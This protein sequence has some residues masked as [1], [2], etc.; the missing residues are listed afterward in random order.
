MQ[1]MLIL[2]FLY[3]G[4]AYSDGLSTVQVPQVSM[5]ECQKNLE[6]FSVRRLTGEDKT[7]ASIRIYGTCVQQGENR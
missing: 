5:E 3:T 4:T 7:Y 1:A 2:W 6:S